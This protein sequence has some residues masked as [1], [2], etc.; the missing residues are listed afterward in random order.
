M[1]K[2]DSSLLDKE[3]DNININK[4]NQNSNKSNEEEELTNSD[5]L[6]YEHKYNFL[7]L[8]FSFLF[9]YSCFFDLFIILNKKENVN[10]CLYVLRIVTDGLCIFPIFCYLG[11][12]KYKGSSTKNIC[13]G[14]LICLPQ[15]IMNIITIVLHFTGE[16]KEDNSNIWLK[17]ATILNCVFFIVLY[18]ITILKLKKAY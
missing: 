16:K 3:K 6:N 11:L 2:N 15:I 5:N 10:L 14:T 13:I 7:F 12:V 18:I 17:I 1:E 8:L 4:E 9:S